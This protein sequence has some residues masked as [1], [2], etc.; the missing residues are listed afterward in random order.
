MSGAALILLALS[1][2]TNTGWGTGWG[3][4]WTNQ[5]NKKMFSM[6]FYKC[7]PSSH[8]GDCPH[9]TV[10]AAVLCVAGHTPTV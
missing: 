2:P 1:G 9:W 8:A 6:S 7:L 3:M 4:G 5:R 10:S